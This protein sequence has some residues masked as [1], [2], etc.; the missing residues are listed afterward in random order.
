VHEWLVWLESTALSTWVRESG[1]LWAYPLVLTAHTVG[2]SLLVG[3]S[4]VIGLR[5][6]G[7]A[8]G[9]PLGPLAV[10]FRALWTGAAMSL[11]S[12][13][14]LF[15][16]DAST[17]GATTV[18]FVKLAFIAGGVLVAWRL[19]RL[20]SGDGTSAG[21][22]TETSPGRTRMLAALSLLLW[23]AAITA[24]RFMAYLTPEPF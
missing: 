1:S 14:L 24:G 22:D 3:A 9:V 8:P 7:V 16:A 17:K 4:A 11:V 21:A 10:V 6:L 2:M 18:F 5:L 13:L 23:A 12:G 15:G 20:F 19:T